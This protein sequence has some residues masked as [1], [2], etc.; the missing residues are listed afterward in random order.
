MSGRKAKQN[1]QI[2]SIDLPPSGMVDAL[3][4]IQGYSKVQVLDGANCCFNHCATGKCMRQQFVVQSWPEMLVV[5]LRRFVQDTSLGP[6]YK[7]T[8]G[9]QLG[10]GFKLANG[11]AYALT[12]I[13]LHVGTLEAGHY[14]TLAKTSSTMWHLFDDGAAPSTARFDSEAHAHDIYILLYKL[15]DPEAVP[16]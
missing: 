2:I 11:D 5:Q 13:V 4:L 7:N 6:I 14:T 10:D 3:G 15:L 9:I 8:C 16:A 1:F 12:G